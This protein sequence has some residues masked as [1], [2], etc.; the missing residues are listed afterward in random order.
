MRLKLT[1]AAESLAQGHPIPAE[2]QNFI[3][4]PF[5]PAWL[6]RWLGGIGWRQQAERWGVKKDLMRKP[7][8]VAV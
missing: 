2:A 7:Y 5:I 4:K 1:L 8:R 3:G 6:Y